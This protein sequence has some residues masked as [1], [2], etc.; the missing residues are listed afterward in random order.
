VANAKLPFD[1]NSTKPARSALALALLMTWAIASCASPKKAIKHWWHK[2][3]L[4]EEKGVF[5]WAFHGPHSPK[6][7]V[8]AG[9]FVGWFGVVL[10]CRD[11]AT[12]PAAAATLTLDHRYADQVNVF[13]G[14]GDHLSIATVSLFGDGEFTASIDSC[15]DLWPGDL[16]RVYGDAKKKDAKE[17][18]HV[19]TVRSRRWQR[20]DYELVPLRAKRDPNGRLLRQPSP[21]A[22]PD[23][24]LDPG[25]ASTATPVDVAI[26]KK[27]ILRLQDRDSGARLRAALALAEYGGADAVEA[28]G[29][30]L[31]REQEPSAKSRLSW[32]LK[33]ARRETGPSW[34]PHAPHPHWRTEDAGD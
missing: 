19:T 30:A 29:R 31:E 20:A 33:R 9:D 11:V 10:D 5:S 27:L 32:C 14:I 13:K 15:G 2:T 25:V 18:W 28:L 22:W 23:L 26:K 12:S 6:D 34:K 21:E 7:G 3:P 4:E 1:R 16:M 17:R 24:T 8:L